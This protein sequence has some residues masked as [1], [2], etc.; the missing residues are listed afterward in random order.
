MAESDLSGY[1]GDVTLPTNHGGEAKGF[2]IRSTSAKK[3][4]SRYGGSRFT[5]IRGGSLT[6]SGQIMFF[7]RAGAANT[8][9]GLTDPDPDGATLTLTA[10]TGCTYSGTA[11]FD[12]SFDHDFNDPAIEGVYDYQF[13]GDVAES[14]ASGA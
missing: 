7:L 8:S 10:F 14:W 11:L 6:V 2:S 4:V 1:L 9:P 3:D 5:K 13:N 12:A